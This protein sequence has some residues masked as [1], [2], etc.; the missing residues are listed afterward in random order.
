M[1]T[2]SGILA[3]LWIWYSFILHC[4]CA[5]KYS[6]H[7]GYGHE[8]TQQGLCCPGDYTLV[9]EMY[10]NQANIIISNIILDS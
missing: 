1:I 6:K 5:R 8:E 7:W 3:N 4:L 2:S 9:R 10:V